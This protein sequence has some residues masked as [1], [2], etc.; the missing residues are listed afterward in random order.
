[1]RGGG[2][3][4]RPCCMNKHTLS[5]TLIY[6]AGVVF[7]PGL[8]HGEAK[9]GSDRLRRRR[10]SVYLCER[11]CVCKCVSENLS[12]LRGCLMYDKYTWCHIDAPT[13]GCITRLRTLDLLCLQYNK[14][15]NELEL[16]EANG[17][18][19]CLQ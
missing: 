15:V 2:L 5:H 16:K 13:Q 9:H 8:C 18:F 11:V 4:G 10:K 19:V 14:D 6:L 17:I 1:M 3:I 12:W 7:H